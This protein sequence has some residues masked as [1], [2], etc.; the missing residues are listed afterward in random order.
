MQT[1]EGSHSKQDTM[2]KVSKKYFRMGL[3]AYI[4]ILMACTLPKE[5]KE[6]R[7]NHSGIPDAVSS[8][9]SMGHEYLVVVA[10]SDEISD[11]EEFARTVIQMCRNNSFQSMK[12]STDFNGYP[13]SLHINVYYHK[14]DITEKSPAFTVTFYPDNWD[15][16]YDIYNEAE[17]FKLCVDQ[18]EIE[19]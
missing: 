2:G 4:C 10:N 15:A 17:H 18:K 16:D 9:S 19:L 1:K 12:F 14:N 13:R 6:Y 8:I 3:V 11:K 7:D 5:I